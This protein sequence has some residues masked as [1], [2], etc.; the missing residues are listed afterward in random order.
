MIDY[1]INRRCFR[2]RLNKC[3][4]MGMRKDFILNQQ[5]IQQRRKYSKTTE[6]ISN[7]EYD[8]IDNVSFSLYKF[9]IDI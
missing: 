8:E 2:C 6:S 5:Q 7:E 3:F 9:L 1:R 4:S